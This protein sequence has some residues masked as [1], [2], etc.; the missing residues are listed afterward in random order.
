MK[1]GHVS[2]DRAVLHEYDLAYD[3]VFPLTPNVWKIHSPFGP[4]ALKKSRVDP[5]HLT[6]INGQLQRL[7][8][9]HFSAVMP[10]VLNKFG[11]SVIPVPSG[12]GAYYVTRWIGRSLAQTDEQEW[13]TEVLRLMARMHRYTVQIAPATMMMKR[14][15]VITVQRLMR[16]WTNGLQLLQRFKETCEREKYPSPF[17]VAFLANS[18]YIIE[19]VQQAI[20][21]LRHW[22]EKVDEQ[23]EMRYVLCH[24][25][26][27]RGNIVRQRK[28]RFVF[29]D[30]DHANMDTPVRDLALFI[31][32]HLPEYDWNRHT[33]DEWLNHYEKIFPLTDDEKHLLAIYLMYPQKI[34][35]CVQFYLHRSSF[36]SLSELDMVH[37]LEKYLHHFLLIRD[38][39]GYYLR[40][41][42]LDPI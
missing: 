24:G 19:T 11:E 21:H 31:R 32:R 12:Q 18:S 16:R 5:G 35:R 10:F 8:A 6:N 7:A 33:A 9:H 15:N 2:L 27:H 29:I 3:P 34:I 20:E 30:F 14:W 13:E 28:G 22:A 4:F 26:L 38:Y 1:H 17:S 36:S 42:R 23:N 40:T 25:R 37:R 39:T 41:R